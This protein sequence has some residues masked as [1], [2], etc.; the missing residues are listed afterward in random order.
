MP[1]V[2]ERPATQ[3]HM[4]LND[5]PET[6]ASRDDADTLNLNQLLER[7]ADSDRAA[8]KAL[9]GL[10]SARLFAVLLRMVRRREVAED[11][12][13]DVFV[14]IWNKAN[15]FDVARGNAYAWL[16]SMT[17][18]KAIDRLR[19]SSREVLDGDAEGFR[20]DAETDRRWTQAESHIALKRGLNTLRPDIH[21]ALQLCYT[22]GLTHE[23]L[24]AEMKVP[25]GTA[26]SWVRRGL[27]QLRECLTAHDGK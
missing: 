13:Q 12:L 17:R 23:E 5:A 19:I 4:S 3:R 26:K 21:R 27:A 25:V 14:T 8:L 18:R 7:I 20:Y 22:Y 15:L 16:F 24:A 10:M 9:Y 2:L 6:A 11:L 1:L